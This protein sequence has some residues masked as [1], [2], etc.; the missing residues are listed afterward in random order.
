MANHHP[1]KSFDKLPKEEVAARGR[2]GAYQKV[3][4]DEKRKT[5]RVLAEEYGHS[6]IKNQKIIAMLEDSGIDAKDAIQDM[7]L[8]LQCFSQMGKGNA[9]WADIYLKI[10]QEGNPDLLDLKKEELKLRRKELALKERLA[11]RQLAEQDTGEENQPQVIVY[12][13][14]KENEK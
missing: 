10:R 8:I 2:K 11:E 3:I 4:N 6:R 9:K 7:L 12:I 5:L 13:P 14:Q 1:E